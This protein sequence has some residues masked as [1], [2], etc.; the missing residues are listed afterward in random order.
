MCEILACLCIT[1]V[2]VCV[3]FCAGSA[4]LMALEPH[5]SEIKWRQEV[6]VD[7]CV[8]KAYAL[9]T[10]VHVFLYAVG[11]FMLGGGQ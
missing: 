5:V 11:H 2:C 9:S 3:C 4:V 7:A 6:S 1:Y 8:C 10:V